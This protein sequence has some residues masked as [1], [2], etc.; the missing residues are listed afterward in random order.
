MW[1]GF[2]MFLCS[3]DRRVAV[4][5]NVSLFLRQACGM[6]REEAPDTDVRFP[7]DDTL[8]HKLLELTMLLNVRPQD[9]TTLLAETGAHLTRHLSPP[10][11][12]GKLPARSATHLSELCLTGVRLHQRNRLLSQV[13]LLI[14]E[15]PR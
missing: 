10:I 14:A 11:V 7:L 9:W 6:D 3:R 2:I 5:Y 15:N 12:S 8:I 1:H 13:E 4:L